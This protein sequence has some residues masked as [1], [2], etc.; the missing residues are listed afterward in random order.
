MD[1][2]TF[3]LGLVFG[4]LLITVIA[5]GAGLLIGYAIG[6]DV[7]GMQRQMREA[8][9][10]W[11]ADYTLNVDLTEQQYQELQYGAQHCLKFTIST[12]AGEYLSDMLEEVKKR[13]S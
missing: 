2:Q 1:A 3:T 5:F 8:Q 4:G 13:E 6:R 10:G 7:D 9:R 11:K 12:P